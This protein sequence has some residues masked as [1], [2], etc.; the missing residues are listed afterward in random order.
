MYYEIVCIEDILNEN[1]NN[2][3]NYEVCFTSFNL[4][5]WE[6]TEILQ[7]SS[8]WENKLHTGYDFLLLF[9]VLTLNYKYILT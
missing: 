3:L 8:V 7:N 5:S 1:F 9:A 6:T 4:F 2:W